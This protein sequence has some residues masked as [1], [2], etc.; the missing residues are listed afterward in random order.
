MFLCSVV[1]C[2]SFRCH[3]ETGARWIYSS[4]GNFIFA[5]GKLRIGQLQRN[6]KSYYPETD[7]ILLCSCIPHY[8]E[9]SASTREIFG[10]ERGVRMLKLQLTTY[11]SNDKLPVLSINVCGTITVE[12]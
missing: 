7:G 3:T 8:R 10:K 12:L 5:V 4:S 1:F 6:L 9:M 11:L 2:C